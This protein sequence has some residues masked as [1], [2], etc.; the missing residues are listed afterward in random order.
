MVF[1]PSYSF[2]K[3]Q[4]YPVDLLTYTWQSKPKSEAV[5]ILLLENQLRK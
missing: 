3:L 4:F 5:A 2:S 1:Y